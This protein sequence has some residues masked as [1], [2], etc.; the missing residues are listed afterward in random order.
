M[1]GNSICYTEDKGNWEAE[2]MM[3][4]AKIKTVMIGIVFHHGIREAK[5]RMH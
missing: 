4:Q 2:G 5:Q 1:S 3:P